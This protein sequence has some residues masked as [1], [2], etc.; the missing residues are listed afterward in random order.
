[1]DKKFIVY[2]IW[3]PITDACIYVGKG[4]TERSRMK[5]HIR[6][7]DRLREGKSVK[8]TILAGTI[9]RIIDSGS[10]P[11]FKV[12]YE[13]PVEQD[14]FDEEIRRIASYGRRNI[15]TGTL[16]NLTE[17]G[18]GTTGWKITDKQRERFSKASA[19]RTHSYETRCRMSENAKNRRHSDETKKKISEVQK[20]K[21][22]SY[23]TRKKI[24]ASNTG[25]KMSE[26]A[27]IKIRNAQLGEKSHKAK[28]TSEEVINIRNM[29]TEGISYNKLAE[30]FV[31]SRDTIYSIVNKRTWKH[32]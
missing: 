27:K 19:G 14:A 28:F 8:N 10:Y 2:E 20:G 4:N 12:V 26:S 25:K 16:A 17:G 13:T 24:S 9:R 3:C 23:D 31:C 32:I 6:Q 18:E 1:M 7:A 11:V 21:K 30:M 5:D 15:N 29:F 22:L